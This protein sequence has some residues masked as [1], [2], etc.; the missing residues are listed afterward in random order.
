MPPPIPSRW[1]VSAWV[2]VFILFIAFLDFYVAVREKKLNYHLQ[3]EI[4]VLKDELDASEDESE[5][6]QREIEFLRSELAEKERVIGYTDSIGNAKETMSVS[7]DPMPMSKSRLPPPDLPTEAHFLYE[8]PY[9]RNPALHEAADWFAQYVIMH[10]QYMAA[11]Q[12]GDMSSAK[13]TVIQPVA[14]SGNRLL[15]TAS[16]FIF[17]L[18][19]GRALLVNYRQEFYA[20]LGDT[21]DSPGFEIEASLPA[22]AQRASA[23]HMAA[24]DPGAN[25]ELTEALLCSNLTERYPQPVVRITSHQ[26]FASM[27]FQNP[28]YRD[29][30]TRLFYRMSVS[31]CMHD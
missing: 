27:I 11:A 2:I 30:L 19:T 15:G 25:L 29:L 4:E 31:T 3:Q 14:Q 24:A 5:K 26:H 16:A 28:N 9:W 13:F 7:H 17:S 21:F 18:L 22:S 6:F 8:D 10:R 12:R 23:A 1:P 20:S